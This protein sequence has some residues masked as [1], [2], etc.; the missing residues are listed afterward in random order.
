MNQN[1]KNRTTSQ[2]TSDLKKPKQENQTKKRTDLRLQGRAGERRFDRLSVSLR[3]HWSRMTLQTT[4]ESAISP[5]VLESAISL[6]EN[7]H[8]SSGER[9][10]GG[11]LLGL[12]SKTN[13]WILLGLEWFNAYKF[14]VIIL[15][16]T[17]KN[18]WANLTVYIFWNKTWVTWLRVIQVGT[19]KRARE[20]DQTKRI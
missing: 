17:D 14:R 12:G 3:L 20:M 5:T 16:S 11:R 7:E 1:P 18:N 2:R 9:E 15:R 6:I 8:G 19:V 10:S 13:S 4:L